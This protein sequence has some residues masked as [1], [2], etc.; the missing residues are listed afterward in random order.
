MYHAFLDGLAMALSELQTDDSSEA[1]VP[2]TG[3]K[4]GFHWLLSPSSWALT[5]IVTGSVR[6]KPMVPCL[7][8]CDK[9]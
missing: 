3:S 9:P 7:S 8:L 1:L 6:P 4:C 5:H 2:F